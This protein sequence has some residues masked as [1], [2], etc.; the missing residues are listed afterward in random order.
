MNLLW[1]P[2]DLASSSALRVQIPTRVSPSHFGFPLKSATSK[3]IEDFRLNAG[4]ESGSDCLRCAI[5]AREQEVRVLGL[6][7]NSAEKAG[8]ARFRVQGSGISA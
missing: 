1:T 5:F 7:Q 3:K 4:L 8:A 2:H 6:P